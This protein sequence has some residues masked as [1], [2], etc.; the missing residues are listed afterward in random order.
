MQSAIPCQGASSSYKLSKLHS[1]LLTIKSQ[2]NLAP[3]G[4]NPAPVYEQERVRCL[5]SIYRAPPD[6]D[7]WAG[8]GGTSRSLEA[9]VRYQLDAER[10]SGNPSLLKGSSLQVGSSAQGVSCGVLQRECRD[11]AVQCLVGPLR[12]CAS[13]WQG[14]YPGKMCRGLR[15][16]RSLF[17]R[18][19]IRHQNWISTRGNPEAWRQVLNP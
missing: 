12:L 13:Y 8:A 2:R 4:Q 17:D 9:G 14:K 3:H 19:H 10:S 11:G 5:D 6:F 1:I 15:C 7:A 16:R 18:E